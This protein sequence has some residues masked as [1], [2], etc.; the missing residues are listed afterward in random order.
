MQ[1]LAL[2]I[3]EESMRLH[4]CVNFIFLLLQL[5][6]LILYNLF[7]FYF[8]SANK[9]TIY[10]KSYSHSSFNP[11]NIK[12]WAFQQKKIKSWVV[13]LFFLLLLYS[14]VVLYKQAKNKRMKKKKEKMREASVK[15]VFFFNIFC[16]F[17]KPLS[18]GVEWVASWVALKKRSL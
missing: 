3:W 10:I 12:K 8:N 7:F 18:V 15:N 1:C 16:C 11:E 13:K 4:V 17:N 9:I 14:V 2:N 5:I 6:S